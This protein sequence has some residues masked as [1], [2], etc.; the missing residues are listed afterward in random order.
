MGHC[1][2]SQDFSS[3][4]STSFMTFKVEIDLVGGGGGKGS[5]VG[6]RELVSLMAIRVPFTFQVFVKK[7]SVFFGFS[8][9][10]LFP[11]LLC[12]FRL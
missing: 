6:G 4:C 1:Y 5:F 11:V 8:N 9:L 12:F 10:R 2:F 7:K 3:G